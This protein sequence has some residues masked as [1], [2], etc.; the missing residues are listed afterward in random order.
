MLALGAVGV[1]VTLGLLFLIWKLMEARFYV[2]V[3]QGKA[4]IVNRRGVPEPEV[5]FTGARVFPLFDKAE[6][7]DISVKTIDID[8]RGK[9]GLICKDNIRADIRVMFFVRVNKTQDDVRKVAQSIGC[10]RASDPRTLE[11]LFEAKFSEALKTAGRK[12]EFA[13]LYTHRQEFRSEVEGVIGDD[14]NGYKLEDVAIDFLEQTPLSA[15]DDHNIMDADGIRK[16]TE[17][18]SKQRA[19][20]N[21]LLNEEKK[22]VKTQDVEAAAIIMEQERLQAD[23]QT[24]QTLEIES[25]KA[26][27][28]AEIARIQSETRK[29]AERARIQA[30]EEIQVME[31]NRQREVEVA[32]KNRQRVVSVEGE[33]A[34][35]ERSLVAIE[36]EREVELQRIAKEKALEEE[37][38]QIQDVI[39]QRIA[40]E[41]T[42]AEEEERIK[43]L[44][45]AEEAKRTKEATVI[46]AEAEAEEQAVK[47]IKAA[48][49]SE[50]CA[51]LQAK[52]RLTLAEAELA[53]ADKEAQAKIRQS[54]GVQAE[55]AA[56]GLAEARVQEAQA[57]AYEKQGMAEVRVKE[58]QAPATEKLGLAEINV[59][60]ADAEVQA[61]AIQKKLVAE[62]TGLAQ[63]A[64][65]MKALDEVSRR[66]EEYRLELE[67]QRII[68]LEQLKAQKEIAEAQARVMGEAFKTAKIDIVGGDGAILDKIFGAVSAGKAMDRFV[69]HSEAA[70]TFLGDYLNGD[71]SLARD[72][73]EILSNPSMSSEDLKNLSVSAL[74]GSLIKKSGGAEREKLIEMA[75]SLGLA[76]G[77]P[78]GPG[79]TVT[80]PA[81]HPPS[82]PPV[83]A[84][85]PSKP[86]T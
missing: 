69:N 67:N 21:F 78:D 32:E 27:G 72:L 58:A 66:H 37:R 76:E 24:K 23:A 60:K 12:F 49:A 54:E 15:L 45:V 42:V 77:I 3:E 26:R 52:Q 53:A 80:A 59:K 43:T 57:I 79:R 86:A 62:A 38:R 7:M 28:S 16:I 18:T 35:K 55:Q 4:L 6:V 63:K 31:Q 44:R 8:R 85:A 40:V 51:R 29:E 46:A 33:R 65:A 83:R 11:D 20:T 2:R 14:L 25:A 13:D 56:Q 10:A 75:R 82:P 81:P 70:R 41:K 5:V 1:V 34:E 17:L 9:E 47:E 30:D 39:R 68:A 61:E 48:E 36:R 71:R 50:A 19:E 64:Q 84:P 74:L 22:K 73:K